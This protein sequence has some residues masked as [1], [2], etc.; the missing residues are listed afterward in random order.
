MEGTK[1]DLI[2]VQVL[3]KVKVKLINFGLGQ[4]KFLKMFAQSFFSALPASTD[5]IMFP[6]EVWEFQMPKMKPFLLLPNQFATVVTTPGHP[7]AWNAPA[8][9]F[10]TEYAFFAYHF[11]K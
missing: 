1:H 4:S 10:T 8:T 5:P 6:T 9:A 3:I 7:V 2:F 11:K